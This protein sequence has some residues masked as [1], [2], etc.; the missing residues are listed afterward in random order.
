MRLDW[1]PSERLSWR[2]LLVIV[3]QTRPDKT[4]AL[5]RS[6]NPDDYAWG[7]SEQLLA[8]LF[9]AAQ[10]GNWQRASDPR[11]PRP[12]PLQ[13]PGIEPES[14]TIGGGAVSIDEMDK[15]LGWGGS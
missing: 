12:K 4:S 3:N 6:L 8:A 1:L 9:D 15:F 14:K 7:L 2:D 13:R 10:I 11:A 5:Y